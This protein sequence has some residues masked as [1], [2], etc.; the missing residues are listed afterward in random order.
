MNL[1]GELTADGVFLDWDEPDTG[2]VDPERYAISFRIPPDAGWGVAT[3]NVGEEGALNTE[4]TL[5]YSLFESTGGLDEE[6]VFDVR[7]D[8]DTLA[9]YSGWSTQVTLTVSEPV[10]TNDDYNNH[11]YHN[12]V[13]SDDNYYHYNTCNDNNDVAAYNYDDGSAYNYNDGGTA[14]YHYDDN[15]NDY[16]PTAYDDYGNPNYE[17]FFNDKYH[18]YYK[19]DNNAASN[20]D[21]N[22]NSSPGTGTGT[23]T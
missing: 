16:N 20:D 23:R 5:P 2:N 1:T 3:G 22:D 18:N 15:I 8:N 13:A 11:Y 12:N 4:Y 6:Y 17:Y 7:S 14:I 19:H 21:N 9:L 10:P